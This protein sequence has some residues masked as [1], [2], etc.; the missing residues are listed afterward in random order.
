MQG[1]TFDSFF[2]HSQNM[3]AVIEKENS[4]WWK[5]VIMNWRLTPVNEWFFCGLF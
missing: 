5:G 2:A 1:R 4:T 3:P